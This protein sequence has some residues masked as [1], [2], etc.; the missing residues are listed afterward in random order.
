[1]KSYIDHLDLG[2]ISYTWTVSGSAVLVL[3]HSPGVPPGQTNAMRG[4]LRC[5][6]TTSLMSD[7]SVDAALQRPGACVSIG[8]Y[9]RRFGAFLV[10]EEV[11]AAAGAASSR[12]A[13][14][15]AG[16]DASGRSA[17]S[18]TPCA[19]PSTEGGDTTSATA[20]SS[21]SADRERISVTKGTCKA[22]TPD[23]PCSG[24]HQMMST[25]S[26]KYWP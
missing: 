5:Q 6:P 10:A 2:W 12:S 22:G 24:S 17:P 13:A 9:P 15:S 21:S 8:A 7:S 23:P 4:V 18:R 20:P 25:C 26:P 1:M 16:I 3:G 19:R 14:R 11:A